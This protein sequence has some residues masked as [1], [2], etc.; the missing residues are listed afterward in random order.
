MRSSSH[1]SLVQMHDLL[2]L[3]LKSANC[4]QCHLLRTVL[5]FVLIELTNSMRYAPLE[6]RKGGFKRLRKLL[7]R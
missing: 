3:Q 2:V 4:W 1:L 7:A 5:S 6:V